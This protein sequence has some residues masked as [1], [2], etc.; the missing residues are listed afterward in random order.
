MS[1]SRAIPLSRGL[2]ATVDA[3]DYDWL[4]QWRW[5]THASKNRAGR[6]SYAA[7]R[8]WRDERWR[9][10]LMHRAITRPESGFVVDHINGDGLDNRRSNLRICTVSQN[11][12]NRRG[13]LVPQSSRFKGV[14]RRQGT[15]AKPWAVSYRDRYIGIFESEED[16]A[17]AYDAA[18]KADQPD[19]CLLN[20]DESGK[21]QL[22]TVE[23]TP[24]PAFRAASGVEGVQFSRTRGWIL[25]MRMPS[26]EIALEAQSL[27]KRLLETGEV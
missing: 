2:F 4:M 17:R 21:E 20:F 24:A 16:A 14:K 9:S 19:F 1:E 3:A 5:S 15:H 27:V 12:S 10:T 23:H 25:D 26:L 22:R 11:N 7:V 13:A 6:Y 8:T 18:A